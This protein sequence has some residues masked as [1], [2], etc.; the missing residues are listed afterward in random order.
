MS[1]GG[2][3]S[4]SRR[5]VLS[6]LGAFVTSGCLTSRNRERKAC[7][8]NPSITDWPTFQNDVKRTGY[9]PSTIN[10]SSD[11]EPELIADADG[12]RAAPIVV[13]DSVYFGT[14][15]NKIVSYT[16]SGTKEWS[17]ETQNWV[18]TTPAFGCGTVFVIGTESTYAIDAVNGNK[19]WQSQHGNQRASPA[20]SGENIYIGGTSTVSAL[21]VHDGQTQW[22]SQLDRGIIQ[23]IALSEDRLFVSAGSD[24]DGTLYALEKASGEQIWEYNLTS[25]IHNPPVVS[26]NKVCTL[27]SQGRLDIIDL[28]SGEL[29]WSASNLG[30]NSPTP[31]VA[32]DTLF[33]SPGDSSKF[34]ALDLKTGEHLWSFETGKSWTPPAVASQT[35]IVPTA[36]NGVYGLEQGKQRWHTTTMNVDSA[37]AIANEEVFYTADGGTVRR[38]KP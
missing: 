5:A 12:V 15:N 18:T 8:T 21:S 35:I 16:T 28:K 9:Q 3:P 6:T 20:I 11:A 22:S 33:I 4:I 23:G 2:S 31:A 24:G 38:V 17:F 19:L 14:A 37:L 1:Y 10:L 34:R 30:D 13:G 27:D 26:G 32:N 36:N 29:E 25:S 7:S